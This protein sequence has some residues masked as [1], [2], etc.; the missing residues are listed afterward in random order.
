MNYVEAIR[1]GKPI[2]REN[3]PKMRGSSGKGFVDP[4]MFLSCCCNSAGM[5]GSQ[6]HKIHLTKDDI[7]AEDWIVKE[8]EAN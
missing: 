1:T 7:L 5:F 4:W 6:C 3:S 8:D 2:A